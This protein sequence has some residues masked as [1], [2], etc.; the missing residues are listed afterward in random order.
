MIQAQLH[1]L[2]FSHLKF[3]QIVKE[4]VQRTIDYNVTSQQ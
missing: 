3:E 1:S 2:I 4:M